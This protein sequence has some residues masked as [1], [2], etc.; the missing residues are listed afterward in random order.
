MNKNA[1]YGFLW[2]CYR[3]ISVKNVYEADISLLNDPK[4][5]EQDDSYFPMSAMDMS[6]IRYNEIE[7]QMETSWRPPKVWS[8]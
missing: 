1:N 7:W 4:Y 3:N 8:D 2:L 5:S 6:K